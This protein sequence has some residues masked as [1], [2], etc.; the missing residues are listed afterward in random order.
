MEQSFLS[1]DSADPTPWNIVSSPG[2]FR[3]SISQTLA[4]DLK[5]FLQIPLQPTYFMLWNCLILFYTV[6]LPL[7]V[8]IM[9]HDKHNLFSLWFSIPDIRVK[10]FFSLSNSWQFSVPLSFLFFLDLSTLSF[11]CG[12]QFYFCSGISGNHGISVMFAMK[13]SWAILSFFQLIA[14][15]LKFLRHCCICTDPCSS[16]D[17]DWI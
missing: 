3:Y 13:I 15:E 17:T 9:C 8:T 2:I 11:L 14:E 5:P 6:S 1:H 7:S 4:W 10:I 12:P 16:W